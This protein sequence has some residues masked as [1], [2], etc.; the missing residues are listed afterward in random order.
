MILL[1]AKT[2]H[3]ES[4][5]EMQIVFPNNCS[6]WLSC[7]LHVKQWGKGK[8]QTLSQASYDCFNLF[9]AK[10][11]LTVYCWNVGTW[12]FLSTVLS[13]TSISISFRIMT[14]RIYYCTFNSYAPSTYAEKFSQES[15]TP[16][17]PVETIPWQFIVFII[18]I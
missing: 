13:L 11:W 7:F 14:S 1:Q 4:M 8:R 17:C 3:S 6:Y 12:R 15:V 10:I 5:V 16:K 9:C 18:T 2:W